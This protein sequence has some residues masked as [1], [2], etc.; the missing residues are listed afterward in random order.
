MPVPTSCVPPCAD[1]ALTAWDARAFRSDGARKTLR[2]TVPWVRVLTMSDPCGDVDLVALFDPDDSDNPDG[3]DHARYR[4]VAGVD[5][6]ATMLGWAR[7]QPGAEQVH[8]VLGDARSVPSTADLDLVL[9]TGNA[10]QHLGPDELGPALERVAA[11]LRAGGL[12]ALDTRNPAREQWRDW[13]REATETERT[14]A[15]GT[16]HEWLDLVRVDLDER[17]EGRVVFDAHNVLGEG[18]DRVYRSTLW[19]RGVETIERAL[20]EA[21]FEDVRVDGDWSGGPVTDVSPPLVVQ[22]VRRG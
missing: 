6:S 10:F 2:A 8:W 21:V 1:A 14:T 19:F 20:R 15:L 7:A 17:G 5:P 16:L 11:G 9:C 13:T 22:A 3:P 12:L 4:A 18:A